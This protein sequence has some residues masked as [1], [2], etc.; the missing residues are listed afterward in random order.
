[1]VRHHAGSHSGELGDHLQCAKADEHA[2]LFARHQL[3]SGQFAR[4]VAGQAQLVQK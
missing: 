4:Q 3:A 2:A 1:M